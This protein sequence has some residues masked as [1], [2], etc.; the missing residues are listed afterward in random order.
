MRERAPDS[1]IN[2]N[3]DI[4]DAILSKSPNNISGRE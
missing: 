1:H 2:P 4:E 3:Y